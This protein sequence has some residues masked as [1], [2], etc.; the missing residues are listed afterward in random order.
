[1]KTN[2]LMKIVNPV[3]AVVFL[4]QITSGLM[5]GIISRELFGT[6]HGSNAGVLMACVLIHLILN[7]NW[8]KANFLK[9]K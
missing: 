4:F 5:H 9:K 3:L 7:W 2:F 1:M 6:I 8:V